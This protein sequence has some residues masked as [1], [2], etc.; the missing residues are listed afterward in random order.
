MSQDGSVDIDFVAQYLGTSVEKFKEAAF[1]EEGLKRERVIMYEL[2][3][4]SK[5]KA[6]TLIILLMI[7]SD[8]AFTILSN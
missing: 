6:R 4:Y 7:I 2:I 8:K 5:T 1:P 3:S